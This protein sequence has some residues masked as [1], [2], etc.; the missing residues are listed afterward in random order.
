MLPEL[1]SPRQLIASLHLGITSLFSDRSLSA[2]RTPLK[3]KHESLLSGVKNIY[4]KCTES[5]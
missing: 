3:S 5:L 2:P 1:E 4:S